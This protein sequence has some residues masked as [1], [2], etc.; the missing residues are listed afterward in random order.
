MDFVDAK[1]RMK[2]I[3]GSPWFRWMLY[4]LAGSTDDDMRA[5]LRE[6][7]EEHREQ[8]REEARKLIRESNN[9]RRK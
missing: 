5:R 4:V 6:T 8:V 3:P 1:E 9:A 7:P 2:P